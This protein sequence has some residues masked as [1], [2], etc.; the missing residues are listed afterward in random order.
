MIMIRYIAQIIAL[1][2]FAKCCLLIIISL[3]YGDY[4][5]NWA[6]VALEKNFV[7]NG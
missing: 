5:R 7:L 4:H 6:G 3:S 1:N 2:R